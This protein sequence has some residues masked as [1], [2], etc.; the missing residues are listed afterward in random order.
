MWVSATRG[1][2][3]NKQGIRPG[4]VFR[5]QGHLN[6]GLLLKHGHVVEIDPQPKAEKELDT[7]PQCEHC[8]ARYMAEWQRDK[9]RAMHVEGPQPAKRMTHVIDERNAAGRRAAHK[10]RL[11]RVGM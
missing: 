6:D 11:A 10:L 5:L 1:F 2:I 4:Q 9:C 8:G 7:Y 3:Y